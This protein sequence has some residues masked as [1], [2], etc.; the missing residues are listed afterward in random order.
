LDRHCER[1]EAIQPLTLPLVDAAVAGLPRRLRL[2]AM[3][4]DFRVADFDAE[5][6]LFDQG[7]VIV[8]KT[9]VIGIESL[10]KIER[11]ILH[12]W[13]S[14]YCMRNAGDLAN[15]DDLC[16]DCLKQGAVISDALGLPK[17]RAF[18][19]RTPEEFERRFFDDFD[20]VVIELSQAIGTTE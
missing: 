18:F 16:P 3:T 8:E 7:D 1:S 17:T 6:W 13:Y 11:L 4:K 5:S 15:L 20:D 2:L 14:D 12:L 10:D 9:Q 19:D